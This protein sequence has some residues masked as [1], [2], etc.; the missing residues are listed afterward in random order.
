MPLS[1]IIIIIMAA[2]MEGVMGAADMVHHH[3]IN[4]IIIISINNIVN[5]N[6]SLLRLGG[7]TIEERI[8]PVQLVSLLQ[9]R[10]SA[11]AL[12]VL[13]Q[14]YGKD[15]DEIPTPRGAPTRHRANNVN[16]IILWCVRVPQILHCSTSKNFHPPE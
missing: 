6:S 7:D 1:S 4:N 13:L 5:I 10:M 2:V 16:C 8:V 9:H 14:V 3:N 12:A 15:D 11:A